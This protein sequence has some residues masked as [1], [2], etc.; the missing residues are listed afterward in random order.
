MVVPG[1]DEG[2]IEPQAA[3]PEEELVE[4]WNE[5]AAGQDRIHAG[6]EDG[7]MMPMILGLAGTG[8]V[9]VLLGAFVAPILLASVFENSL[10]VAVED[11]ADLRPLG[12]ILGL[13]VAAFVGAIGVWITAP[14]R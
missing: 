8:I 11:S 4:W 14:R 2:E 3:E 5:D 12:A 10:G 6:A 7:E 9:C 13:L 1:I